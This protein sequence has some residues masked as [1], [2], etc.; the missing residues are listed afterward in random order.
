MQIT[1]PAISVSFAEVIHSVYTPTYGVSGVLA[2][3]IRF[4]AT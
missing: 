4:I 3:S 2:R 1:T